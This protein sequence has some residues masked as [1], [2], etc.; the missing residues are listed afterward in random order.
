MGHYLGRR[1]L[2]DDMSTM[3]AGTRADIDHI[4]RQANRVFIVLDHNHRVADIPQV[5]QRAQET[6]IVALVQADRR[7]IED[8]QHTHQACTDLAGQANTLGFTARQGIGAAVQRQVVQPDVNQE[9]QAL[10]NLLEDLVG[11][12]PTASG[13]FEDTKVFAGITDRQVGHCRQGLLANPYVPRLTA[14]S[15][16]TAIRAGLGAEKLGQFF[17]HARRLGLA[18]AAFEVRHD[19]FERV[20]AFDDVATVVEVFEVDALRAA[21]VENDLLLIRRQLVERYFQAELVVRR[22]RPEH[23]EVID[24]TPVPTAYRAFRQ[25]QFAIDQALDVEELLHPQAITGRACAGR[26]VEG[27]Q[28]GFQLADGVATDRAGKACGE[29]D[30][31][32]RLVVHRRDQGNPVRQLQGGLEGFRQA[33]LQVGA[34]FETV[35]HDINRVLLLLV[36]LRRFVQLIQ[37]AV[38]PRPHETLRP[39]FF[40]HRKVFTLALANYR[41]QQH[42]LG[43]F[44]LGQHQVDHLADGLGFQRN[45]VVRAAWDTYARIEQAQVVIDLGDG[46]HGGARIMGRRLMLDRDR[47]RRFAGPGQT[48][49]DDQFVP[50]QGQVDI[51]QVVGSSPTNQDL[52]QDGLA[53]RA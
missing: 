47:R 17:T 51:L 34:H 44:R 53:R 45:V 19:A 18:V 9:L 2:G 11:D 4:I 22:Q 41:R 15:G 1:T 12:L 39:Q 43:A 32:A 46:A 26:V 29:D 33:L 21:A 3:H 52:V 20:R 35:D 48:G 38:D 10:E 49:D 5:L 23:L 28:L 13:Q 14:Q 8:I 16:A 30:L 24:V 25:R 42:Q 40:K 50:G 36:E 7:F 37:L 31:F 27:K 6:I